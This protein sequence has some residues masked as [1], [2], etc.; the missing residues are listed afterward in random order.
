M[1]NERIIFQTSHSPTRRNTHIPY[2]SGNLVVY[3]HTC[4]GIQ[5]SAPRSRGYDVFLLFCGHPLRMLRYEWQK[6]MQDVWHTYTYVT[7]Q[8][9][10]WRTRIYTSWYRQLSTKDTTLRIC[11]DGSEFSFDHNIINQTV[12][13]FPARQSRPPGGKCKE[14][15]DINMNNRTTF[16]FPN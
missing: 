7:K 16:I 13:A 2:A 15:S 11:K 4:G 1:N 5:H 8:L 14:H 9:R 10:H 6:R 12:S 3:S